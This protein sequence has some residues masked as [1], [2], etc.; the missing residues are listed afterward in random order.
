MSEAV[1]SKRSFFIASDSAG[2]ELRRAVVPCAI[3]A[4]AHVP[5]LIR[6]A[7]R[8]WAAEHYQFFP[9][10]LVGAVYLAYEGLKSFAGP[11]TSRL[12]IRTC[13][14]TLSG[15]LLA[16]AALLA[17]PW[18]AGIAAML[19]FWALAYGLGGASLVGCLWRAW[20]FLWLAVPL[21]LGLDEQLILALQRL[22]TSW[23]SATLD[24]LGYRHLVA[25]VVIELP[26]RAFLVEEACS[27]IHSLFAAL[28]CTVFYL[29]QVRRGFLRSVLLVLAAVFWVVVANSV[30]VMLVTVLSTTWELPVTEGFLHALLGI[31]V[32]AGILGLMVSTDRLL[33]F[34][35]PAKHFLPEFSSA[36]KRSRRRH[37]ALSFFRKSSRTGRGAART[38]G[39]S[40][41]AAGSGSRDGGERDAASKS[42][43]PGKADRRPSRFP[44]FTMAE[45]AA[46]AVL[47]TLILGV[48]FVHAGTPTVS[49]GDRINRFRD[50]SAEDLPAEWNG[51]IRTDFESVSR[52][53]GD[54]NGLHSLIWTFRKGS[55]AAAISIDGPFVGWH[56]LTSCLQGQGWTVQSV[57]HRQYREID[58]S[59]P[60]G[61][62]EIR[63]AKGVGRQAFAAF[64]VFDGESRPLAP[65]ETYVRFRAVRRFPQLS[66]LW[67]QMTGQADRDA[68]ADDSRSFQVHVF[69]ENY[70]KLSEEQIA[71]IQRLFH[72][73]RRS[74]AK[75]QEHSPDS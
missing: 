67:K 20:L 54:P 18:L 70:T 10:I 24:L 42:S 13:L 50:G 36:L 61:F 73:M 58:E 7:R 41:K 51:W 16:C 30:R 57:E 65:S 31:F 74:V 34:L 37:S 1:V 60:G 71:E 45:Y 19:S 53:K 4:A 46:I 26:E 15:G 28:A 12:W 63:A 2:L 68:A 56:N 69:V 8:L 38:R 5:L 35:L 59:L 62:T 22:A 25:G 39:N 44:T 32:F 66:E 40:E 17:S 14:V 43:D 52:K 72:H 47:Y 21:P 23:A 64:A 3:V 55:Q 29:L 48:Q 33:M 27:G 6:L 9:L 11:G 49:S 75:Q